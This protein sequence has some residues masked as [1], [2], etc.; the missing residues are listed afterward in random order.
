MGKRE[1]IHERPGLG[2]WVREARGDGEKEGESH[3]LM[4]G[5]EKGRVQQL[6]GEGK[7]HSWRGLG[8]S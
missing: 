3:I 5:G 4:G 1:E 7:Y 2:K 8:A 6:E